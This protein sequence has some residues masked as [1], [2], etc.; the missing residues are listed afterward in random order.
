MTTLLNHCAINY[1]PTRESA[2]KPSN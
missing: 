1:S 2:T